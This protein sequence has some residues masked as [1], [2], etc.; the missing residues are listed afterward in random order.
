MLKNP[1][2]LSSAVRFAMLFA[3]VLLMVELAQRYVPARG[4]YVV[5]ALAGLTDVDAITLSMAAFARDGGSAS[6]AIGAIVTAAITNTL[7]KTFLVVGLG[8]R[9]LARRVALAAAVV[10]AAGV[11]VLSLA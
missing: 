9:P 7:V 6:T 5:A 4:V 3:L 11:V 2:S 8:S 1:F 10:L